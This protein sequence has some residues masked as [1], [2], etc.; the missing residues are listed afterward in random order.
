MM[1]FFILVN[2]QGDSCVHFTMLMWP[3]MVCCKCRGSV[4]RIMG[5]ENLLSLLVF[6]HLG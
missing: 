4:A 2:R 3:F 1:G 5:N 6:F